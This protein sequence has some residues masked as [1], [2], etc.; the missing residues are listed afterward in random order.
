MPGDTLP[1][2]TPESMIVLDKSRALDLMV[3]RAERVHV[4]E[5]F[6][7]ASVAETFDDSGMPTDAAEHADLTNLLRLRTFTR[8]GLA[9]RPDLEIHAERQAGRY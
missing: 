6:G 4:P 1:R 5:P 3:S 8:P 2:A 7:A 9:A